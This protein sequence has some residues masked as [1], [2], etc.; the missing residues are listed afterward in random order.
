MRRIKKLG[1]THLGGK[2]GF[3]LIELL[4]VLVILSILAGVIVMGMGGITG[5][6][7]NIA[8]QLSK[9]QIQNAVIAHLVSP[10]GLPVTGA[11]VTIDGDTYNIIDMC[12]LTGAGGLLREMP[13][14][15][16]EDATDDDNCDGS[17]NVSCTGCETKAHYIWAIEYDKGSVVS[18][19]KN[20]IDNGGGCTDTTSDGFQDVWP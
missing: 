5:R 8:Y 3:T 7:R 14:G 4:I 2:R 12:A 20:T 16:W 11:T 19:C 15:C 18:L 9:S 17:G 1:L 13:D 6:T 10:G